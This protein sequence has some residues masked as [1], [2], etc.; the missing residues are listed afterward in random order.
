MEE[1]SKRFVYIAVLDAGLAILLNTFKRLSR[2]SR[3]TC[4][5]KISDF[6]CKKKA[7]V[8]LKTDYCPEIDMSQKL[9]EVDSA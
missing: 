6:L 3:N 9:D 2:T 8:V 5:N 7:K 1:Q 4:R